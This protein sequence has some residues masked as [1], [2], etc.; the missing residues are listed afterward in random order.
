M[1]ESPHVTYGLGLIAAFP[2]FNLPETNAI[3]FPVRKYTLPWESA[4]SPPPPCQTPPPP[5]FLTSVAVASGV[6]QNA[7]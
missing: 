2:G 6:V 7:P 5:L 4:A 1:N 3:P